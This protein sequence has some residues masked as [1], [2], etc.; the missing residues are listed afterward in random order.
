VYASAAIPRLQAG[1]GSLQK[2]KS[3]AS[4]RYG[5]LRLANVQDSDQQGKIF[6]KG[7][8]LKRVSLASLQFSFYSIA[9][10]KSQIRITAIPQNVPN[11][12]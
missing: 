12:S 4:K 3:K 9:M 7:G 5:S 1:G 10:R 2:A 8:N 11:S 6:F